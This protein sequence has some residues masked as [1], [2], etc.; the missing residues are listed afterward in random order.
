MRQDNQTL[1]GR[2]K[3]HDVEFVIIGGV[4]GVLH[5]LSLVTFDL[6]LCCRFSADNLK[7]IEAAVKDLHPCHRL[8]A[9]KLP[10]A[11]TEELA[12]RLRNLYLHTDLGLL[13][14]LSE[15]AGVGDY[16]AVLRR[17]ESHQVSWGEFRVLDLDALIDSK[18]ALGRERDLAAVKQ[19]RAIK[20]KR[21]GP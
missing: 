14:C 16:E 6:D 12:S 7:R 1:L 15:V 11:L 17:S 18:E 10:F 8:T 5:G 13:D 4:C 2:L 9:D 21:K 19:L 3:Q 20:E